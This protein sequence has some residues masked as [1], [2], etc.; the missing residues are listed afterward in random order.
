VAAGAVAKVFLGNAGISI[1]GW[2]SEAAGVRAAALG[3]AGFDPAQVNGNALAGLCGNAL[4][5]PDKQAASL[6]EA[7][8]AALRERGDSCGGIVT[9]VVSGLPAGLGDPV[10]GKL[11]ALLAQAVL[12]IGAV[13]GFEI[14]AG[15]AA[16]SSTGSQNNDPLA[17]QAP[18]APAIGSPLTPDAGIHPP[19]TPD[20]GIN[21][22]LASDAGSHQQP[23]DH[24]PAAVFVTNNAGGVSGGISTGSPLVFRA[25]FKPV[26]SIRMEQR[27]IDRNGNACT[28]TVEGRHD[29]CVCPRAVPVVE[30]MAALVVAD[31]L[32]SP[33]Q[34]ATPSCVPGQQGDA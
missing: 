30:A 14:G 9:C 33:R 11:D 16:A 29:A 25:A 31:L 12:S 18:L 2:V 4:A 34:R 6:A 22:Q 24:P 15:F 5:M 1:T 7:R 26:P 23:V 3:E 17:P 10:F 32:V 27:T 28:L 13:K 19:L 20:A 8:I 21:P